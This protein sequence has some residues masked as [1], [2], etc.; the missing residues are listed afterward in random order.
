[1]QCPNQH[2]VLQ[3]DTKVLAQTLKDWKKFKFV[4]FLHPKYL[5]RCP[6]CSLSF[7]KKFSFLRVLF[8]ELWDVWGAQCSYWVV[9]GLLKGGR[10]FDKTSKSIVNLFAKL[11]KIIWTSTPTSSRST[12]S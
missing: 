12:I 7:K 3:G 11:S 8:Y 6:T 9:Q 5:N 2:G 4:N 10:Y 1:L